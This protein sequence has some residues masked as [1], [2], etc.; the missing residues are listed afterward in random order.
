MVDARLP[1]GSRVHAVVRP[2][3]VDGPCLTIRRF[4][5]RAVRLDEVASSGVAALLA[6]AV[7][8]RSNIVV[9]GG[10]GAGKTTLLNALAAA[11]PADERVITIEDAAE[12]RL[13]GEHVVRL[14][15]RP[16]SAEGLG[17]VRI[18][19]LLRSSLR[20]R[21]D[22]IVVGEVRSGE[23]LDM[24]Q[25]MNTG[26]EGSL[27]TC[28]AN[29]PAEALH[30][31]ETMVLMG[32]VDL[33]HGVVREQIASA[34]DLVVHI[35]RSP[36]GRRVTEV[37]E[38]GRVEQ[39]VLGRAPA[40]GARPARRPSRPS[41]ALV[42]RRTRRRPDG[43]ADEALRGARDRLGRGA[44]SLA[45]VDERTGSRVA[46]GPHDGGAQ[47]EGPGW[48]RRDPGSPPSLRVRGSRRVEVVTRVL[49]GMW[50]EVSSSVR[51]SLAQDDLDHAL[52]LETVARPLRAGASLAGAVDEALGELPASAAARDLG[53]RHGRGAR[54]SPAGRCARA[55][56]HRRP[57]AGSGAGGYGAGPGRRAG[58]CAGRPL[59]EAAALLRDRAALAREVRALSSQARASAAVMV[60]GP[61]VFLG[62][63]S[64]I[65]RRLAHVL[66][67]TP[68]G[69]GCL[70]AGVALDLAGAAWMAHLVGRVS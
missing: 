44:R 55:V 26:H 12:L 48:P 29:G 62:V 53:R 27:S 37:A 34:V 15:A 68:L 17:E 24:L 64:V 32:D 56:E 50:A 40:G 65:D 5:A 2:L 19:D 45:A 31:L 69:L 35:A 8:A 66:F 49:G 43:S 60:L 59:E 23:A 30:R 54:R 47:V 1:D 39:G 70:F 41:G 18:R 14:E 33:P 51:G 57:D 13:P 7:R 67:A 42:A 20:M 11:I 22:R 36:S 63:A 16:A 6:W 3:A 25:A 9:C 61:P 4:G 46:S 52:V 38:V 58:G 10:A 21:P 28:H